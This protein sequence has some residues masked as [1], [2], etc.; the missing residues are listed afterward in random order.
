MYSDII[1]YWTITYGPLDK[2]PEPEK[3]IL[4]RSGNNCPLY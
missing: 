4:T 1:N 2:L 3:E